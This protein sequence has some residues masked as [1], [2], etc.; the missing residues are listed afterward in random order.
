MNSQFIR[1]T[2]DKISIEDCQ[3]YFANSKGLRFKVLLAQNKYAMKKIS[4]GMTYL[5]TQK[6]FSK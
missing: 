3:M 2:K 6:L 5:S 1:V 4:V